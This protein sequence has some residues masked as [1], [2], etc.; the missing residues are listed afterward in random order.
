MSVHNG[1]AAN[2]V[3]PNG[4]H[5]IQQ[6]KNGKTHKI[7]GAAS[8]QELEHQVLRFRLEQITLVAPE[9]ADPEHVAEDIHDYICRNYPTSCVDRRAFA[10]LSRG[11]GMPE[12][13]SELGGY[14]SAGGDGEQTFRKFIP[15]IQRIAEWLGQLGQEPK[16]F[17]TPAEADKRAHICTQCPQNI[18]FETSCQPCNQNVRMETVRILGTRKTRHD[19]NLM[20]CRLLGH[21]NRIAV[22]LDADKI[23]NQALPQTCWRKA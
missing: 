21:A 23:E 19:Q 9:R 8:W 12:P 14:I 6:L 7:E 4:F 5:F 13:G 20:G 2:V 18:R 1:L 16:P 3:P 15:L 17:T 11:E 10:D 22:W